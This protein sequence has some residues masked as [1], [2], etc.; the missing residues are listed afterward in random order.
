MTEWEYLE[1]ETEY[2][3]VDRINGKTQS[4][5]KFVW[6]YLLEI[7]KEGW[8]VVSMLY[9]SEHRRRIYLAKRIIESNRE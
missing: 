8:E 1:F 7:G 5:K 4:E 2:Y 9:D 6:Q 3:Q